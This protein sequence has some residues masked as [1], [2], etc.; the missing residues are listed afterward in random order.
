GKSQHQKQ[1]HKTQHAQGVLDEDRPAHHHFHGVGHHPA[2]DRDKGTRQELGGPQRH[3]VGHRGDGSPDDHHAQEDGE[4][5][6]EHSDGPVAQQPRKAG[7]RELGHHVACD[8]HRRGEKE[9][10]QH[11]L[12]HHVHHQRHG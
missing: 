7:Q 4:P 10:R 5:Q 8:A 3:A 11:H 1:H 2:H 6:P 12:V 9:P